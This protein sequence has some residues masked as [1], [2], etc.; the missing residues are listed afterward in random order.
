MSEPANQDR[1]GARLEEFQR[2]PR[3][4]L[5]TLSLPIMVGMSIYTAYMI[6][7]MVFVGMLGPDALI[8][9]SFTMPLL[10]LAMGSTFGLG[11]AVTAMIAQAI[12]A[13]DQRRASRIAQHALLVGVLLTI[14]F[15]SVGLVY[16]ERLL[17]GIG[18]PEEILPFAWQYFSVVVAGFVFQVQA[19]LFRSLFSGEGEVKLPVII[20]GIG[21]ATNIVLDPIF[22]FSL[23]M[24][25]RGAAVATVV[26][27]AAVMLTFAY[28]LFIRKRIHV[29]LSYRNFRLRSEIV[30]DLV[31]IGAPASL[32]FLVMSAGGGTFNRILVEYSPDAVAGLQV[33][34]RIDHLVVLPI[35][36]I[37]SALVTL[38]GMFYGA[39]RLELV[40]EIANYAIKQAVLIAVTMSAF[41]LAFAPW[42]VAPFTDS[43]A[44][45][46]VAVQY[47]RYATL[48]F[49]AFPFSI[50][51]GRAQQGLDRGTPELVLSLL[52]VL[53]I[54]VPLAGIFAFAFDRPIQYVWMAIIVGSWVS[55]VVALVW[56]RSA[57]RSAVRRRPAVP[58]DGSLVEQPAG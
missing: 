22:I 43:E 1:A 4:A 20:S 48:A 3:K 57:L 58:A 39:K 47:L 51:L 42:L 26:T 31:R 44:I 6:A 8:A 25:I 36:S 28:L 53:L 55:A 35:V 14:G 45:R 34:T 13:K 9:V 27:Q 12:G 56:W 49:V 5:W 41:F 30:R 7:D 17:L 23:D 29:D 50:L 33:G 15:V 46:V 40:E 21:T 52:R 54:S 19:I 37:A 32:S 10:F 16:G 24:G 2:N 18:V 11:S 38:V